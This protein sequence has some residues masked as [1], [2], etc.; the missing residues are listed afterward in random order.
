MEVR[1]S[2]KERIKKSLLLEKRDSGVEKKNQ[3]TRK[4]S[5]KLYS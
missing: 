1:N 4:S 2:D 5:N 3:G